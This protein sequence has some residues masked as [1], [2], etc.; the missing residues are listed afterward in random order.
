MVK[1]HAAKQ[2][3]YLLKLL[4]YWHSYYILIVHFYDLN[5]LKCF[6]LK[7]FYFTIIYFHFT[8]LWLN[9]FLVIIFIYFI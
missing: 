8:M 2:T 6:I 3:T 1:W 9:T 7:V 4:K 5:I